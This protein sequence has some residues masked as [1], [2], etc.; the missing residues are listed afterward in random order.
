MAALHDRLVF[1]TARGEV[2]D[3]DRRYLLMRTD[4]LMGLFDTLPPAARVEALRALGRSVAQ[5]GAGSVRAYAESI[6]PVEL[7]ATMEDAAASLGWGRWRLDIGAA[8]DPPTLALT[9]EN[10]PFAVAAGRSPEP[11]CH[12]IA[13]MLQALA[14]ALWRT[15]AAAHEVHCAA[16]AGAGP[17]RFTALPI[18]PPIPSPIP[19]RPAG[20]NTGET[21]P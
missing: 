3:A 1:D 20:A 18:P 12:A 4:V 9:V 19:R 15:P 2:R 8:A 5:H 16:V 13:G 11:V 6:G 14:G 17:C 10:S 7:C 21:D